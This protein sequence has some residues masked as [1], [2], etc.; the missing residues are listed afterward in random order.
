MQFG[1]HA[2]KSRPKN[3]AMKLSV[4]YERDSRT[5]TFD[6][7]KFKVDPRP[8]ALYFGSWRHPST[9]NRLMCGLNLNY[10]NTEQQQRLQTI[11]PQIFRAGED[12]ESGTRGRVRRFKSLAQ[13]IFDIGYRT[14]D[15]KYVASVSVVKGTIPHLVLSPAGVEFEKEQAAEKGLIAPET[16]VPS[17]AAPA[18]APAPEAPL[19]PDPSGANT[20]GIPQP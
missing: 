1:K 5:Y 8:Q 19:A 12:L 3:K 16:G 10:L 20:L 15:R 6:Y 13:D 9:G 11:L 2:G 4:L 14:Y 18:P 17:T 7:E